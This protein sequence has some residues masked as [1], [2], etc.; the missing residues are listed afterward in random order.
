MAESK[1]LKWQDKSNT[2]LPDVCDTL[3]TVIEPPCPSKCTPDSCA[4]VPDWKLLTSADPFFNGKVCLYQVTIRTP[5][6]SI[7]EDNEAL[8]SLFGTYSDEAAEAFLIGFNKKNTP[9][10]VATIKNSIQYTQY[11][12]SPR[13]NSRL[14][15]LY[16]V[17]VGVLSSIPTGGEEEN[18]EDEE[19]ETNTGGA[20]VSY[21]PEKLIGHLTKIRKTLHL[22]ETYRVLYTTIDGGNLIVESTG[23]PFSVARYGDRGRLNKSVLANIMPDLESFFNSKGY[24]MPGAGRPLGGIG[25]ER[26]TRFTISFNDKYKVN[27]VEIYTKNCE[28]APLKYKG[29]ALRSLRAK[30]SFKDP[31]AMAYFSRL[32]EMVQDVMARQPMPWK[33]FLIKYTYPTLLSVYDYPSLQSTALESPYRIGAVGEVQTF[34][35]HPENEGHES[36]MEIIRKRLKQ[37]GKQL[38]Q[39]INSEVMSL[40]KAIAY[41]FNKNLCELSVEEVRA[42]QTKIGLVYNK[43]EDIH[44]TIFAVAAEQAFAKVK[45]S[46][47]SFPTLCENAINAIG[48]IGTPKPPSPEAEEEEASSDEGSS[49]KVPLGERAGNA[50]GMGH[51]YALLSWWELID[52]IKICGLTNLM[53]E[54]INCL[55]KGLTL[56]ES[57]GKI[58]E[59]ALQAM[60]VESFGDFLPLLP[61]DKR[62]Q[63]DGTIRKR[64]TT[65]K[66]A[67]DEDTAAAISAD[68]TQAELD[69]IDAE[70]AEIMSTFGIPEA[71]EP[72]QGAGHAPTSTGDSTL[73]E[74]FNKMQNFSSGLDNNTIKS[75]YINAIIDTYKDNLLEIVEILNG[76]PGAPLVAQVIS[77]LSCPRPPIIEPSVMDFIK[78]LE[79]PYCRSIQDISAPKLQNPFEKLPKLKDLTALLKDA[80]KLAIQQAIISVLLKLMV[81]ICGRLGSSLCKALES[82][83]GAALAGLFPNPDAPFPRNEFESIIRESIVGSTATDTEARSATIALIKLLGTGGT[84]FADEEKVIEFVGDIS[85]SSTRLELM[86]AMMGSPSEDFIDI[87]NTLIEYDYPEFREALPTTDSIAEFFTNIGFLMPAP[88]RAAMDDFVNSTPQNDVIPANPSI[89]SNQEELDR[90]CELRTEL[91]AGRATPAQAKQMCEDAREDLKDDLGDLSCALQGG[92]S[93]ALI[94]DLPSIVSDPGCNDGL[95]PFEPA[96]LAGSTTSSLSRIIRQLQRAYST[97]LLGN[98][99]FLGGRDSWGVLN[100]I[101]SD[102]QGTPRTR[103]N[104]KSFYR[105]NYV[106]FYL[107]TGAMDSDDEEYGRFGKIAKQEGAYPYK[108]ADWLQKQLLGTTTDGGSDLQEGLQFISTNDYQ[109][110]INHPVVMSDLKDVSTLTLPDLGYNISYKFEYMID[111]LYV[112]ELGRKKTPDYKLAFKDNAKGLRSGPNA[113]DSAFAYGFDLE[114]FLSDMEPQVGDSTRGQNVFSDNARVRIIEYNNQTA[115]VASPVAELMGEEAESDERTIGNKNDSSGILE[116]M[117]YEFVG[118]D[119]ALGDIV[120][121]WSN[122][123]GSI[124]FRPT[125]TR[126]R[127]LSFQDTY[128]KFSATLS[129]HSVYPP[130]VVLLTEMINSTASPTVASAAVKV[131]YDGFLDTVLKKIIADIGNNEEMFLYGA[132]ADGLTITDI[133]YLDPDTGELYA[134][135][136]IEQE[137]GTTAP[138]SNKNMIL[139]IS[140]YQYEV[141]NGE[142]EGPNRVFYLNPQEYGGSYINPPLYIAPL[143]QQG[144]SGMVDIL[145]PELNACGNP[146]TDLIDFDNLDS[147]I[148][149]IHPSMAEEMRAHEGECEVELPYDR[150]LK[151]ADKTGIEGLLTAAIRIHGSIHLI[152]SI[153]TF[154]KFKAAFPDMFSTIYA[155]YIVESM[156]KSFKDAQ[157]DLPEAFNTFKDYEFWYAFL[158]QAVQT[159]A[160]RLDDDRAPR[161]PSAAVLYAIEQLRYVQEQYTPPSRED[162]KLAK[163]SDAVPRIRTLKN[164][165]LQKRLEEVAASENHAKVIL[166][167]LVNEQLNY[168]G[169]KLSDNLAALGMGPESDSGYVTDMQYYLLENFTQG[170][171]LTP[172]TN[173]K[174]EVVGLPT[175]GEEHYTTGG[176]F[177][178]DVNQS[179]DVS[180]F[181]KGDDYVGS[182]HVHVGNDGETT[183]MAGEFHTATPHDI[184]KPTAANVKLPIGDVAEYGFDTIASTEKPFILEKYISLNGTKYAP[185]AAIA[186]IRDNDG[187]LNLSDIYPGTLKEKVDSN[188]NATGIEGELGARYGLQFSIMIDGNKHELVSVELDMLDHST[189]SAISFDGDTRLM[190]CMLE[191]LKNNDLFALVTKYIFPL[192]K[193]LS[194]MAIYNDMALLP[195]IG[196][197]TVALGDGSGRK[198]DFDTKPGVGLNIEDGDVTAV[199]LNEGWASYQERDSFWGNGMFN[200]KW[201]KWDQV[202]LSKSN[203]RIKSIF[204]GLYFSRDFKIGDF[205][206]DLDP[207]AA[208][209]NRLKEA[210]VPATG[211]NLLPRWQRRRLRR[212]RNKDKRCN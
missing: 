155:Q 95:M 90:F 25:K 182:Y 129:S 59:S 117:T 168:M 199:L 123:Y 178:V 36:G 139:G 22:Y 197:I 92:I 177:I 39:D 119:G 11:E 19:G 211:D 17:S 144:W 191:Q 113:S 136:E 210:F 77:S 161:E 86:N 173:L 135:T 208:W 206:L 55:M 4:T 132:T 7:N 38:G 67:T 85:A 170:S 169:E 109:S 8:D 196:E 164:Y 145:F 79:L 99:G 146:V 76:F 32:S 10:T 5:H 142:R 152:L 167:E 84:E 185:A 37:E 184:L 106:D 189:S 112:T 131:V 40:G 137:D 205:G 207:S 29:K 160:R 64:L 212:S 94:N 48:Q 20:S 34:H 49:E 203:K 138:L 103:H 183:Y 130:Q 104:R 96:E 45:P 53:I 198:S 149:Q 16:S 63:L 88:V 181:E 91:L 98:G 35:N 44:Q 156:E 166:A 122:T 154:T 165:Q 127:N 9:T 81:R 58:V 128:P 71:V 6:I 140:R 159:Y 26:I 68:A 204:K 110:T 176:E 47:A 202:L 187:A 162:L 51:A 30:S 188:G 89:C 18:N 186:T 50:L 12:L 83:G 114:L 75:A 74:K 157:P 14:K 134:E 56:Q 121:N 151:R 61:D 190:L 87:I 15:L 28:D 153:P 69:E 43:E 201:D 147:L 97:D 80:A 78:D 193:I 23:K 42:Q 41:Q 143:K 171:Y 70:L 57:L 200:Q 194:S 66:Y 1:F 141:E 172:S 195:S 174:E 27:K 125:P 62:A 101:M 82:Y 72:S 46:E 107:D 108:V 24:Q 148:G 120:D 118:V 133:E 163:D 111:R 105:K 73:A 102:T 192:S 54:T 115:K 21:E 31:T 3:E 126:K 93:A 158:E 179:D 150:I 2:L 100:M 33:E 175:E 116:D 124:N 65:I 60:P 13:A 180:F 209:L 52:S